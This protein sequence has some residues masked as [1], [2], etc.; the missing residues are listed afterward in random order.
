MFVSPQNPFIEKPDPQGDEV[1]SRDKSVL[2][3]QRGRDVA[4]EVARLA[5][6]PEGTS[7]AG[8]GVTRAVVASDAGK[9][10]STLPPSSSSHRDEKLLPPYIVHVG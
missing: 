10:G 8:V 6:K 4:V 7:I 9:A 3:Q 2:S 1:A 5:R